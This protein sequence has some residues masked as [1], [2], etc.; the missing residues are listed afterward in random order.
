MT[1]VLLLLLMA[2]AA[3][4]LVVSLAVHLLSFAGIQPAGN[5]LFF[6]LHIG[7]F[8]LWLP[9]MWMANKMTGG[10][11]R[12]DFWKV[13]FAGC[14]AWMKYMTYGFFEYAIVNFA[15]FFVTAPTGKPSDGAPPSS[16]WH[17]FSGH[18]MAFYSAGLAIVTSA[19]R[20]GISNLERRCP[21]GH[22]IGYDDRFCP[23]CGVAIGDPRAALD[24]AVNS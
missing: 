9:V 15:I 11:R 8:P 6:A 20:R 17:G 2:Y 16:V 7:I 19:Y 3:A 23:A 21:N 5:E 13:A 12:M 14:P 4:G 1:N 18:W 22:A 10:A 24:R